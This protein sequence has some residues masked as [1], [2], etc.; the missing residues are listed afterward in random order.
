MS[1]PRAGPRFG[2]WLAAL[3]GVAGLAFVLRDLNWAATV[4]ATRQAGWAALGVLGARAGTQLCAGFAWWWATRAGGVGFARLMAIRLA[5]EGVNTLLPFTAMG[6]DV[7][8]ARLL[9]RRGVAGD[10]AA[11]GTLVDVLLQSAAQLVF[12]LTGVAMLAGAGHARVAEWALPGVALLAAGLGGFLLLQRSGAATW[13]DR[14]VASAAS[15]WPDLIEGRF[16]LRARLAELWSSPAAVAGCF[17]PHLVGWLIDAASPWLVL[18]ALGFHP[19]IAEAVVIES[20][21]QALRGAAFFVPGGVGVQEGALLFLC[22]LYGIPAEAAVTLS[23]VKRLV[24]LAVG[25]PGLA[26]WWRLERQAASLNCRLASR[27]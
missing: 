13:L 8:G 7:V 16:D 22:G 24:D 12:T 27:A 3:A 23:L 9:T 15:R 14:A 26:L 25:A 4:A 2:P 19:T 21:S 20:L 17:V 10:V 1:E 6:G 11:A 18:S 5:R